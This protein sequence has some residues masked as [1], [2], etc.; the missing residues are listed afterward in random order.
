[1]QDMGKIEESKA[2]KKQY[3]VFLK[4]KKKSITDIK[5]TNGQIDE[6]ENENEKILLIGLCWCSF[7]PEERMFFDFPCVTIA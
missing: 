5:W 2:K 1:M 7:L 4:I 6:N 3:E